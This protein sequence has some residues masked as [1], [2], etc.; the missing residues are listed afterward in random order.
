M[1]ARPVA[2]VEISTRR[3]PRSVVQE[4]AYALTDRAWVLLEPG[5]RPRVMRVHLQPR[6]A[7]AGDLQRAL[8]ENL[9]RANKH[10]AVAKK[11]S[12]GAL[13]L[14]NQGA[15]GVGDGVEPG[16]FPVPYRWRLV[17]P[18]TGVLTNDFGDWF[19][20]TAEEYARYERRDMSKGEALYDALAERNF[21][22]G[23]LQGPKV[24]REVGSRLAWIRRGPT[25]HIITVATDA[26]AMC[27]A[28]DA[29]CRPV[30]TQANGPSQGM[31]L[32]VAEAV[33]RRVFESPAPQVTVVVQGAETLEHSG[34][35]HRLVE[36]AEDRARMTGK[37][38]KLV[39]VT[40]AAS[41]NE[42]ELAFF[43]AHRVH[44]RVVINDARAFI[45]TAHPAAQWLRRVHEAYERSGLT[46]D[47]YRVEAQLTI[48]RDVLQRGE[49]L[50]DRCVESGC[51]VVSFGA[52]SGAYSASAW[53]D[54]YR[55]AMDHIVALGRSG[56]EL[57]ERMS[58]TLI[59]RLLTGAD[60]GNDG[61]R[62]PCSAGIGR[63]AYGHDGRV[64]PCDAGRATALGGDDLFD[65]GQVMTDTYEALVGSSVVR[66][67][68]YSSTLDGVPGCTSCVYKRFCSVCP[69]DSYTTQGSLV[70][71]MLESPHCTRRMG[72]LDQLFGLIA[73]SREQVWLAD[74]LDRW[75]RAASRAHG[76][77]DSGPR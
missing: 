67:L 42:A 73:R 66:T 26:N 62:S 25:H 40:S 4:A 53:G 27:T 32:E 30:A 35:V 68:V 60:P 15:G 77:L 47:G 46:A 16:R 38:L 64:F 44:I 19:L 61:P 28:C 6:S 76:H 22:G 36:Y 57:R 12:A 59:A 48:T 52:P 34:V 56:S 2:V 14:V 71:R 18:D 21:I 31:S 1:S 54:F 17:A 51:T 50:I 24:V 45:E 5:D 8:S 69:V 41:M 70:G 10:R 13:A 11:G 55:Q 58:S 37:G 23:S 9:Q 43:V 63:L 20:L 72:L 65:M 49:E 39:L 29:A 3:Y 75:S 7:H 33:V 74:L